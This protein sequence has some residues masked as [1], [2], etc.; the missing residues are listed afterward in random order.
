M[1]H[2]GRSVALSSIFKWYADDFGPPDVVRH[3]NPSR[4]RG[5][6]VSTLLMVLCQRDPPV[7]GRAVHACSH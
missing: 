3:S 5:F 7:P 4:V 1:D 2:E 6:K